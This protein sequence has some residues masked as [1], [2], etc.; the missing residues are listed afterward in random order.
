MDGMKLAPSNPTMIQER[1][2]IIAAAQAGGAADVA[3]VWAGFAARGLGFSASN[4]SGNTVV[5][6][7]DLPNAVVTNGLSMSDAS[8][9]NDGIF[10]PGESILLNV[11]VINT[12]GE[13]ITGITAAV[14]GGGSANYGTLANGETSVRQIAF[15]IPANTECGS[16]LQIS[17]TVTSNR[18]VGM[19]LKKEIRI[20]LVP[21]APVTFSS[22]AP[23]D[24]PGG[25]P[26]TT[27]GPANPY[28][29]NIDVS[30]LT[31][32][33]TIKVE[34]TGITHTFPGDLDFLLV[35]PGGQKYIMLSDSGGAGDVNNLTFTLS[36]DAGSLPSTA[37]WT[38][39]T[40]KP[41]ND[42][43][44]ADSFPEPAG[45]Y[46]SAA[47]VG[48]ATFASV[49]GTAASG[50]NGT[51]S[52]YVVDDSTEDVGRMAGWKMIFE[53]NDFSCNYVPTR[54]TK[55]RADFDGDGRTDLSVFRPANGNWFLN[56]SRD[57]FS[58]VNFGLANDKL[59][60]GDYDGDG[61]TDV[62]VYRDGAWF[63][64]KSSDNSFYAVG[65][66]FASDIVVPGDYDG[67][68]KTDAAVFRPSNN[69]WFVLNSSGSGVTTA[70]FG[71]SGDVPVTGDFDGDGRTD[72]T[73]FRRGQWITQL[74]S[75]AVTFTT[76]GLP[77]DKLVP[78]DYDGD[79]KT[80]VAVYRPETGAWYVY[81]STDQSL[82]AIGFGAMGDVAVPGDYD[83]DGRDDVAVFR[84]GMWYTM[85]T[86]S[87][88]T[89]GGFGAAGDVPAPSGYLPAQ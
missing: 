50:M 74:S 33:K 79:K 5:E 43:T 34:I 38:S 64:I 7:F 39:G 51:W 88:L 65:F 73:V 63:I 41:T 40:F 87:G 80:D 23:I 35:G 48:S 9:D 14:A 28:P 31:G 59:V 13:T 37:Q 47:P 26:A 76:W 81:K 83:G 67:D 56:R 18:G 10:E 89:G 58:A 8:G 16:R 52:L 57:G 1:D 22:N 85:G 19:P 68:G 24:L 21:T 11:P 44:V 72:F 2:A 12:T 27:G 29:S 86:T 20:G 15:T 45:P 69:T 32:N 17:I 75:G 84:S 61:R 3:D 66:G 25:Q 4:P 49:F 77:S 36:D 62:A 6:S 54:E 55:T 71:S 53:G 60:P 30:G 70:G 82:Y 46:A 78:G 42:S